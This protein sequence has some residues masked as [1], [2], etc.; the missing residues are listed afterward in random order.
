MNVTDKTEKN[1]GQWQP[2]QSGNPA[3]RPKGSRNRYSENF[4]HAFAQD[5]EQHGATVIEKVR[6][7]RPQ[8][9]LKVAASLLPKEMVIEPGRT[10]PLAELSDAELI[11]LLA[12][13]IEVL[14]E[15]VLI[16]RGHAAVDD[17]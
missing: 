9:Y 8:D 17:S 7:E 15:R 2:G 11:E 6:K 12:S 14:V 10:R 3:G 5:F 16:S 13:D 4:M 1:Q